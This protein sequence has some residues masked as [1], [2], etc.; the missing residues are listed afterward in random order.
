MLMAITLPKFI[1]KYLSK[2]TTKPSQRP[3]MGARGA[4]G[5]AEIAPTLGYAYYLEQNVSIFSDVVLKL[6][7]E[8]F[9]RGFYW[10]PAFALKCLDCDA[11]Y[12]DVVEECDC[13]ST[14]LVEP[15]KSQIKFFDNSDSSFIESAN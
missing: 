3:G 13:G 15:D 10:E 4:F 2:K 8:M 12:D 5:Q 11:E 14:N 6:K 1:S 9:R 7:Q